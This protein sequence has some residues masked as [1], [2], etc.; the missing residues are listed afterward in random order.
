MDKSNAAATGVPSAENSGSIKEAVCI[1]AMRVYDSCSS[2]EYL[3]DRRVYF[4]PDKHELIEQAASVRIRNAT[5]IKVFLHLEPVPFN[6]GFYSVDLNFFFDVCLDVFS[7]Q[8]ACPT[9]VHGVCTANKRVILFGSE[10]N[11]KMFVSGSGEDPDVEVSTGKVLPKA[12]CQ[13]SEPIGLS[14]K[15]CDRPPQGCDICNKIPDNICSLYGKEFDYSCAH[16]VYATIG[17]FTIVQLVRTVPILVPSY[18]FHVPEKECAPSSDSPREM[19]RRIE[20]PTDDFFPPK[21]GDTCTYNNA[22]APAAAPNA[23]SQE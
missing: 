4:T 18:D 2:K 10:G 11:V 1:N 5:V 19:F 20:F 6:Q 14:A 23:S 9:I 8:S 17:L 22:S 21:V 3:E 16:S 13:V 12:T 7:A 15:I